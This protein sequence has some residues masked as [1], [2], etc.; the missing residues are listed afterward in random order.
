MRT[1]A[2]GLLLA[3]LAVG[4]CT[5]EGPEPSPGPSAS[6]VPAEG[7]SGGS[8]PAAEVSPAFPEL[9]VDREGF[10]GT[11]TV[12]VGST[13]AA[14]GLQFDVVAC[15]RGV[16]ADTDLYVLGRARTDDNQVVEVTVQQLANSGGEVAEEVVSVVVN[17]TATQPVTLFAE[18]TVSR[19]DGGW[20]GVAGPRDSQMVS[21]DGNR[22]VAGPASFM[23]FSTD[24]EVS[25]VVPDGRV[26]LTCTDGAA[27]GAADDGHQPVE[28]QPDG[29]ASEESAAAQ[30]D[31]P[32]DGS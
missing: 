10:A 16:S 26:E 5:S 24:G 8:T 29:Q 1:A 22:I 19:T 23:V 30:S 31:G 18:A 3:A 7:G 15:D 2:V 21:V 17:E 25:T 9:S 6:S 27:A 12:T 28:G 4:G 13:P 20:S 14:G 11:G 32:A